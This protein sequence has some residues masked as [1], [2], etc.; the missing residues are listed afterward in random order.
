MSLEDQLRAGLA[1]LEARG[2]RLPGDAL[3]RLL[4]YIGLLVKWN[5]TYNLTAIREPERMVT[6]HVLD[7]LA[8]LEHLPDRPGLRLVDVGSGP[9][10]PGIPLAVARPG[11]QITLLDSNHKKGAFLQQAAAELAL[12]RVRVAIARVEEFFPAESFDIVISRAYS[13]LETFAGAARH[14]VAP[15]GALV[16][17]KGVY[18]HEELRQ[19]PRGLR[20]T[21]TPRVDVPGLNATRHLVVM[22]PA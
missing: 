10:V 12:E 11:W 7:S 6:H 14:L 13:D 17:M 2:L 22:E 5:R 21:A 16:A 15:G 20:V 3:D 1:V 8:V 18:P 4:R 9:G 19:V